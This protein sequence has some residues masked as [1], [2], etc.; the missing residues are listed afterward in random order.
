MHQLDLHRD[1]SLG[2][3]LSLLPS[4]R[5]RRNLQCQCSTLSRLHQHCLHREYPRTQLQRWQVE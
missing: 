1:K 2:T 5:R 3:L 4:M